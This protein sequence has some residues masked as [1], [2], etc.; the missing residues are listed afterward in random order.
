MT[1]KAHNDYWEH[2]IATLEN[3]VH[4]RQTVAFKTMKYLNQSEKESAS[5][6]TIT[7]EQWKQHYKSLW[8]DANII[9]EN[10]RNE[11][12]TMIDLI[13][14]E[15]LQKALKDMK[16][17]KACGPDGINAELLKYG[18][19]LL[20]FRLLHLY[21]ICWRD[22]RIPDE[23]GVSEVISLFKK[24]DRGNCENYRGISL[25]NIIYKIYVKIINNRIKTISEVLLK[26]EQ[27]GFRK[28]RSCSDNVFSIKRILEKRREVNLETHIAF[29][30]FEK[31]F[32]SVVR[33]KLWDIMYKNGYPKHLVETVKS[34]YKNTRIIINAGTLKS[35][36]IKINQGVRQGCSLSPTLFCIYIDD[37]IN[38]WKNEV[39]PGIFITRNKY[40]NILLY[41]DDIVIIQNSE[42]NLQR[43]VYKLSQI[44]KEYNLKISTRKTKV[45]AH[46]GKHP[47]RSKV[48]IE[49]KIL[50]QVSY[51]D[52]LGCN[53]SYDRDKD[54]ENKLNKFQLICGTINRTLQ[55]KTR[56]D[57]KL[58]F[59]KIM[60]VPVLMFGSESWIL[61][62]RDRSKIQSAEMKFL[63]RVKG[64]TKMDQIRNEDIRE[65]LNI[66][67]IHEKLE[68]YK[69]NWR[70]HL[71]RMNNERIPALINSYQ[72][73]GRRDIGRPRKRW[74]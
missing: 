73:Q 40:V 21:N 41:A 60:A 59:Y 70:T 65:E 43:S 49:N 50:E 69:D 64:C 22:C 13:T 1:R 45:M 19:L 74:S 56:K 33:N 32:D 2:F 3:D 39:T 51:F 20:Q 68:E 6:N 11:H 67:S 62:E 24:G 55:N 4:G 15:E 8:Y 58:K 52:Y 61:Q 29:I 9:E 17:R 38:K 16:N 44:G 66:Y 18:G 46:K 34:L 28:G 7:L 57:T 71:H 36:P 54:I 48:V 42:E 53:V 35:E 27:S 23:W 5:I 30:D 31:A 47:V 26:E 63:R 37:L 10:K 72:P 12:N 25:L 14:L